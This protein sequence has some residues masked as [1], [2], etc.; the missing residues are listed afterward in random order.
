MALPTDRPR[1]VACSYLISAPSPVTGERTT[2]AGRGQA[3]HTLTSRVQYTSHVATCCPSDGSAAS[4]TPWWRAAEPAVSRE[5]P[6]ASTSRI[7]WLTRATPTTS[8]GVTSVFG[9]RLARGRRA[10]WASASLLSFSGVDHWQG[11]LF[12]L[13]GPSKSPSVFPIFPTRSSRWG[14]CRFKSSTSTVTEKPVTGE[15]TDRR[16]THCGVAAG[17]RREP[18]GDGLRGCSAIVSDR[19]SPGRRGTAHARC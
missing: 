3:F 8:I 9:D 17:Q 14:R 13:A 1:A 5:P 11:A 12:K 19:G 15:G 10:R 16:G 6:G 7:L 2:C 4:L 18:G